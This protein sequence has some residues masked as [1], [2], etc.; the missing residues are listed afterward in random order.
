MDTYDKLGNVLTYEGTNG[1]SYQYTR[2]DNREDARAVL[3]TEAL[4]KL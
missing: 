2:D 4:K 3:F 1:F